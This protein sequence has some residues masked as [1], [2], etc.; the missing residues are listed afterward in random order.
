MAMS[1][2]HM[3]LQTFGR[4]NRM[5]THLEQYIINEAEVTDSESYRNS[6]HLFME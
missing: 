3:G 4:Q 5:L 2:K 1:L 6:S